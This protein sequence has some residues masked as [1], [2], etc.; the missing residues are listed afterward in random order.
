MKKKIIFLDIDGVLNSKAYFDSIKESEIPATEK[1]HIE[2]SEYHVK[3]LSELCHACDAKIVLASTWKELDDPSNSKAYCMYQYLVD[4]LAQYD[5]EI[6]DKTPTINGCRPYEIFMW[7]QA[8]KDKNEIQA[9]ILDDDFNRSEYQKYGL[10]NILVQTKYFVNKISDGGL[11]QKH[12]SEAI[13][14]LNER[15]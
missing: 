1:I 4:M 10:E 11:Q 7:L 3:L 15:K 13:H 5:M 9:V 14:I 2:I 12:V 8:R 6:L